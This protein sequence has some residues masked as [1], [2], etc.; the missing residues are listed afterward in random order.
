MTFGK[1]RKSFMVSVSV[2]T[3]HVIGFMYFLLLLLCNLYMTVN[4]LNSS[5][6]TSI[7]DVNNV[8]TV[9][10]FSSFVIPAKLIVKG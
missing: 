8:A 4:Y 7:F 5:V 9:N 3:D 1:R 10:Y 2:S 6:G